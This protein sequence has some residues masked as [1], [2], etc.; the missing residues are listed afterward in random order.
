MYLARQTVGNSLHYILRESFRQGR[1]ILSRDLFDLGSDPSRYIVYPGHVSFH[2]H[3]AVILQLEE[4]AVQVN[5]AELEDLFLPFLDPYIRSKMQPFHHRWKHRSWQPMD[6][7]SRSKILTET[8]PVDRR[9]LHF[10]RCGLTPPDIVDKSP[11]LYKKLLDKSRDEIEQYILV[12]EDELQPRQ[13]KDYLY[14]SLNLQRFFK[15]SF[16]RFTPHA[17]DQERLDE[18]FVQEICRLDKD[19]LF[20]QGFSRKTFLPEYLIRYVIM[21]FDHSHLAENESQAWAE[22]GKSQRFRGARR[23][24]DSSSSGKMSFAKALTVFGISRE[25]LSELTKEDLTRIYR[26]KAHELHPDK[27]GETEQFIELTAAYEELASF[28]S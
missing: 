19:S 12:M 18:L 22:Y 6:Q 10:L 9:R 28:R 11:T 5:L 21:Y 16:I 8:H 17:L 3:D 14:T 7:A 26:K 20:W 27:G 13:Y 24:Y 4:K 2:I 23:R 25:Q 15:D 1:E